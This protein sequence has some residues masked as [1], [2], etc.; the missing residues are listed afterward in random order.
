MIYKLRFF[1]AGVQELKRTVAG[2]GAT[3]VAGVA[4][5]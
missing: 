5:G 4:E 3:S 2:V 1:S